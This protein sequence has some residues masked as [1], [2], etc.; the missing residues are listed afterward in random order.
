MRIEI[1]DND[2]KLMLIEVC[3][4]MS[5]DSFT[6]RVLEDKVKRMTEHDNYTIA[7][8]ASLSVEERN[9]ALLAYYESK[10]I[11]ERFRNFVKG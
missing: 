6:F 2:F 10:G 8:N 5:T 9:K 3:E 4:C 1:S 11:P 7:H